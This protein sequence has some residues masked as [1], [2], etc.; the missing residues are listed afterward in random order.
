MKM[1]NSIIKILGILSFIL[2]GVGSLQ[3]QNVS[4]RWVKMITG[5]EK[6]HF[7]GYYG[8]NVWNAARTHILALETEQNNRLPAPGEEAVIGLVEI[9]TSRFTPLTRTR[10]WNLQQGCMLFW[11][12][13]H[14]SDRFYFNDVVNGRLVSVLYDIPTGKR[15]E[16][17]YTIS[18]L[19]HD[20]RY[21]LH[22]NYARIS[23]LRKVVSYGGVADTS[24][25]DPH[26]DT[27]GVFIVDL[28][29]GDSRLLI[30][31]AEIT[32]QIARYAPQVVDRPMWIEH[33]EFSRSDERVLFLPRTWD[34]QGKELLT[35]LYTIRLDGKDLKRILPYGAGVS[36]FGWRN[37]DQMV[38]TCDSDSEHSS[39]FH[40]LVDEKS[41]SPLVG[42]N[43][44]G[45]CSFDHTG[46]WVLSDGKKDRKKVT[47]SVWLFHLPSSTLC[48][49]HTF[50]MADRRFLSGDTRC[51]LHPRISDDNSMICVDGI[52][53]V[54]G[55][56]QIYIIGI[57]LD[58]GKNE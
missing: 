5:P 3:A 34:E 30:S 35:G 13:C 22:M 55:L 27:D 52:D 1:R 8:I 33:A 7:F 29:T 14:P 15:K 40:A 42:M 16:I 48:R 32:R 38:V 53:P 25:L 28:L 36:H 6:N 44:D 12:P 26:P 11:D 43:W 10:A 18:G 58:S 19:S 2:V 9:S 39:R 51:D 49:V 50:E 41:I 4:T 37:D 56:R 24:R 23:R 47:N 17:P 57:E 46:N 45:H 54:T 31:Y 20:G 21:A